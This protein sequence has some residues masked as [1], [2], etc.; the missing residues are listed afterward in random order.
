MSAQKR[1]EKK[2]APIETKQNPHYTH[3]FFQSTESLDLSR[4]RSTLEEVAK[5]LKIYPN[6]AFS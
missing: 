5:S 6:A 3:F 2:K 4:G 1:K